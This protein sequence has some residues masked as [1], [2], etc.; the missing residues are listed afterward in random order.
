MT[1][2]LG[3]L[4]IAVLLLAWPVASAASPILASD[5][6]S[7]FT[8]SSGVFNTADGTG[9]AVGEEPSILLGTSVHVEA[10]LD[11]A[12]ETAFSIGTR[13]VGTPDLV[14]DIWITDGSSTLL[15]ADVVYV[16]VTNVSLAG[17]SI[18]IGNVDGSFASSKITLTG[19]TLA[20]SFG[21][22]GT[23]GELQLV[24]TDTSLGDLTAGSLGNLFQA[25]FTSQTNITLA[26]VPEPLVAA[27][28]ALGFAGLVFLG[29]RRAA[30]RR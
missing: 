11:G 19:G 25:D 1:R 5:P 10:M 14:P 22:V 28:L 17:D 29:R 3:L 2:K 21:G 20:G 12:G 4:W 8:V 23:Q 6:V 27:Q 26:F 7:Q 15:T 18:T 16:D 13:F 30:R 9:D 24:L